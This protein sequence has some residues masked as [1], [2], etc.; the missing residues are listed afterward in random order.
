MIKLLLFITSLVFSICLPATETKVEEHVLKNG[1]RVI[2]IPTETNGTIYFGVM[3]NVG[4]I[5]DPEC[6]IGLS[7]FLEHMM[8]DGTQKVSKDRLHLLMDKYCIG[9]NGNTGPEK[10]LYYCAVRKELLPLVMQIEADRMQNLKIEESEC[11]RERQIILEEKTTTLD[12]DPVMRYLNE[13]VLRSIYVFSKYAYPSVGYTYHIKNI[14]RESLVKHYKKYYVPNNATL[15]FTGSISIEE[16]LKLAKKYFASI[17]PSKG[18]VQRITIPE[19]INTGI[20]H[21]IEKSI[22]EIKEQ[23]YEIHYTFDK[24]LVRSLKQRS[25]A[26]AM[27]A[28][29][30]S[31]TAF[32]KVMLDE[33]KL[34]TH[35]SA[36][37][38]TNAGNKAHLVIQ[39]TIRKGVSREVVE[40]ECLKIIRDAKEKYLT[41]ELL[42]IQKEKKSRAFKFLTDSPGGLF[43]GIINML[44]EFSIDEINNRQN[45]F[46]SVTLEEVKDMA[47][48]ILQEKNIT[49]RVYLRPP[50]A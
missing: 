18:K 20:T 11:E 4:V 19:P 17:K 27:I 39:V 5:D 28:M 46:N 6:K 48:K 37:M 12:S 50:T 26:S 34:L 13:T 29:L 43:Q 2:V 24:D 31:P 44:T 38:V 22:P 33:K 25:I 14:D 15:V 23:E 8:F 40:Q 10:T 32:V 1:L 42:D 16:A 45:I 41:Q 49:H 7:H 3:Y 9:Y 30:F 35:C 21:F 36:D 47:D